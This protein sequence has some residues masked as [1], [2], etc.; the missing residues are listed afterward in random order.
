MTGLTDIFEERADLNIGRITVGFYSLI[1]AYGGT[2]VYCRISHQY[3]YA[4]GFVMF[5]FLVVISLALKSFIVCINLYYSELV[6]WHWGNRKGDE[7]AGKKRCKYCG[8]WGIVLSP[9]PSDS[10]SNRLRCFSFRKCVC[11]YNRKPI[12]YLTSLWSFFNFHF[13][14]LWVVLCGDCVCLQN[15]SEFYVATSVVCANKFHLENCWLLCIF[16]THQYVKTWRE[17]CI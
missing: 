4:Y 10:S 6:Q 5:S 1:F 15:Y 17:I 13:K 11:F 12:T 3:A 7:K 16:L 2:W 9:V 8:Q 14:V